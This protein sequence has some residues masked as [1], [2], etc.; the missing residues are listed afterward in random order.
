VHVVQPSMTSVP[1]A[2][3]Q[4]TAEMQQLEAARRVVAQL[5][6]KQ[7]TPED[8]SA[9]G[10]LAAQPQPA[11]MQLQLEIARKEV[12]QLQATLAS[13]ERKAEDADGQL[14]AE[15]AQAAAA[16]AQDQRFASS[17]QELQEAWKG[18]VTELKEQLKVTSWAAC[19]VGDCSIWNGH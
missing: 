2:Q 10:Q 18:M 4:L 6:A 14:V 1:V 7:R 3:P 16:R 19:N 13:T 8:T 5:K 11:G 9:R 15:R 12:A 17:H